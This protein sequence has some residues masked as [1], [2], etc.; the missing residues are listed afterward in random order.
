MSYRTYN[1][2]NGVRNSQS[3][4]PKLIVGAIASVLL[5]ALWASM[6]VTA[7]TPASYNEIPFTE[8]ELSNFE[9][10]RAVPSGGFSSVDGFANRNDVL[11]LRIEGTNRSNISSFYFTEGIKRDADNSD[12]LRA[13]LFVDSAWAR[14]WS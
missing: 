2:T 10:D 6:A 9:T 4:L 1:I 12:T 7:A 13:D 5:F 3:A 11:E 8:S 14:C